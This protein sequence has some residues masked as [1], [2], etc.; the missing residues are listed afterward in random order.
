[1][2]RRLTNYEWASFLNEVPVCPYDQSQEEW[3]ATC[4]GKRLIVPPWGAV[5]E[6]N[7][8]D[9]LVFLGAE[10]YIESI[11]QTLREVWL[12]DVSD[13]SD[14]WKSQVAPQYAVWADVFWYSLPSSIGQTL[15]SSAAPF[16]VEVAKTIGETIAGITT[17]ILSPFALPLLLIGAALLFMYLPRRQ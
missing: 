2:P 17:P 1:M 10:Q 12:T 5:V 13:M 3:A 15:T 4:S 7:G 14:T 8:M 6:W 16:A 11:N 9:I